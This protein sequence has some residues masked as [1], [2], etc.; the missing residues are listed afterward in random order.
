MYQFIAV[1]IVLG[2]GQMQG[3]VNTESSFNTLQECA[4]SIPDEYLKLSE[5]TKEHP[6]AIAIGCLKT[7]ERS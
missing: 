2:T 4:D 3:R 6:V 1:V 5:A 7:G